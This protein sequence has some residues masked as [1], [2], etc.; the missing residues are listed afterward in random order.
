[1]SQLV[2]NRCLPDTKVE[3]LVKEHMPKK[4]RG[5]FSWGKSSDNKN[6]TTTTEKPEPDPTQSPN[7]ESPGSS[8][9]SSPPGSPQKKQK[10][11]IIKIEEEPRDSSDD[12]V[13]LPRKDAVGMVKSQ[14]LQDMGEYTRVY[15]KSLKLTSEDIVRDK[16]L[17]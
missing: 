10:D 7:S 14:S 13:K 16:V 17:F 9:V 11:T 15:E 12:E 6:T 4:S 3:S 1:M 8:P 5:W 2:F